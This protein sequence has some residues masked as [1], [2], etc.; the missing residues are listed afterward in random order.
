[1]AHGRDTVN[2][3]VDD[4]RTGR[5]NVP[6]RRHC[7]CNSLGGSTGLEAGVVE[8]QGAVAHVDGVGNKTTVVEVDLDSLAVGRGVELDGEVRSISLESFGGDLD[9][10]RTGRVANKVGR[11]VDLVAELG[12][13]RVLGGRLEDRL[14]DRVGSRDEESTVKEEEGDTVVETSNGRLRTSGEALALGL[15][16]VVQ[17]DFESRV[18]S[19]TEPLST[20][21]STVDPGDGTVSENGSLNHTTALR[22][23]VHLP[24]RV[25]I[26]R[27]HA[28]ARWVTGSSDILVR[29]ATADDDIRVPLVGTGEGHHYGSTSVGVGTVGTGEIRQS[30]D[31]VAGTDV[32]DLS[33]LGNLDEEVAILHQVEERIHVVRLVLLKNL[34]ADRLALGSTVGIEDLVC[35]VVVL[36]LGRVKTVQ[37]AGSD[38]DLVVRHDLDRCVPAGGVELRAGLRP[39]LTVKGGIGSRALEET[40]TLETITDSR[41]NEVERSVTTNRNEASVSKKNTTR[42]EGVGLVGQRSELLGRGVVLGGVSVLAVAEL[43]LGV[44]LDLVKEDNLAVLHKTSV[45]SR[46]TRA[47]LDHNGTR[48]GGSGSRA[49]LRGGDSRSVD[50]GTGLATLTAVSSGVTTVAVHGAARPLSPVTADGVTESGTAASVRGLLASRLSGSSDDGGRLAEDGLA[51]GSG[52]RRTRDS[53]GGSSGSGGGSILAAV[54]AAIS[55]E[56]VTIL[57]DVS[58]PSTAEIHIDIQ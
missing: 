22:H 2:K 17:E 24:G 42:A 3:N 37:G 53:S 28:T 29:S 18:L 27:L 16:G 50:T 8:E 56:A 19:N 4:V 32:E 54:L 5:R 55:N 36:R 45:H 40:N 23:G 35:G 12:D 52:G 34:H 6:V 20:L 44:V 9:S 58:R 46:D 38:E 43:E 11:S 31:D 21:L 1:L 33:G 13:V 57:G 41:V 26:E 51:G 49:G 47:T 14:L 15:V 10:R 39:G 7:D 25:G 48:L 30:A